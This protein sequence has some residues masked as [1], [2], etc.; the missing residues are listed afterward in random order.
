MKKRTCAIICHGGAGGISFP[1]RR[2]RG[3]IKATSIGYG[4]LTQGGSS[5]DAA[6]QAIEILE[7]ASI[8]NAGTGSSLNL[9]GNAEMDAALMTSDMRFGGIGAITDIKNP[10]AV[11]RLVM[12]HTDHLLLC[13]DQALRF[14]RI[15]GVP[16]YDP[17]TK[18]KKRIWRR[19]KKARGNRYFPKTK[20]FVKQYG[21]VGAVAIDTRGLI[22]V[23]TSSGGIT[24]RLPGRVGDTPLIGTGTYADH[25][26]GVSATGHGEQIMR[27]MIAF[28]AVSLMR[29]YAARAAAQMTMEYAKQH[30]CACGLIGIDKHGSVVWAH[31][32]R[33]M[34]WCYIRGGR[35]RLF[36]Y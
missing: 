3:L 30:D 23:A 21:T 2:A 17:V 29:R 14:A 8:F 12:E 6:Q 18:E 26:G 4:I 35:L 20:N 7:D 15:M 31:N 25:Y 32:T 36:K 11:A 5:L 22:S 13:G 16:R 34:S 19:Q 33:A 24:L 10:I 1:Q 27:Y 28:R 9:A